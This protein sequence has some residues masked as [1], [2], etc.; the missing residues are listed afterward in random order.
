V[1]H[2][3]LAAPV[4]RSNLNPCCWSRM[5]VESKD[6]C[7]VSLRD[8]P[9]PLGL[10]FSGKNMSPLPC[11]LAGAQSVALNMSNND[12][13]V[14]LHFALFQGS[15]GYVLKP[16]DMRFIKD[17]S[18]VRDRE[19]RNSCST[20]GT[21]EERISLRRSNRTGAEPE[22]NR[23]TS[24]SSDASVMTAEDDFFWPPPR[25]RLHRTSIELLSLHNLPKVTSRVGA[26]RDFCAQFPV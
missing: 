14:Q 22:S 19:T 9:F 13:S 6:G 18:F 12:V 15:D 1:P 8:S 3:A 24:K 5:P 10:R 11:W 25:E 17:H 20:S 7:S 26:S 23:R 21:D 16:E 2:C 4:C